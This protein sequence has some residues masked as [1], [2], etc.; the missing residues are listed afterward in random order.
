MENRFLRS[1]PAAPTLNSWTDSW[2]ENVITQGHVDCCKEFGHAMFTV[3]GLI[4]DF[5]PRCGKVDVN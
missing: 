1:Y 3:D 4:Q 5:C 2:V